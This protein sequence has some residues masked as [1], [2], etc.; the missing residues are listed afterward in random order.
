MM[1]RFSHPAYL[2]PSLKLTKGWGIISCAGGLHNRGL[3]ITLKCYRTKDVIKALTKR[4]FAFVDPL[5]NRWEISPSALTLD[6]MEIL[7][8]LKPINDSQLAIKGD[9]K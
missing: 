2:S 6:Y 4:E 1:Q 8:T 5:T 9:V 3:L 7:V